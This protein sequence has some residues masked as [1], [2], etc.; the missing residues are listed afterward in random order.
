MQHDCEKPL[1]HQESVEQGIAIYINFK[2][3]EASLYTVVVMT[4]NALFFS[5]RA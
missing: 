2:N 1:F 3:K 4:Y 5:T